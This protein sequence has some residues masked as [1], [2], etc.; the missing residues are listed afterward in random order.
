M[1]ETARLSGISMY[2]F[3]CLRRELRQGERPAEDTSLS[4]S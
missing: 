2:T 3:G 1:Y 4:P